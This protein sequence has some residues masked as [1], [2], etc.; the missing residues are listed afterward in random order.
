M[1]RTIESLQGIVSGLL[2][3]TIGNDFD[4]GHTYHPSML[5]RNGVTENLLPNT[6]GCARLRLLDKEF[7]AAAAALHNPKLAQ[8]DDAI[9]PHTDG[10][11]P[12]VDG[13]PRLNGILDT[14]RASKAHNIPIPS[15]FENANVIN[16]VE[17]AVC[18]EWFGAYHAQ[19]KAVRQQF[20][21]LAMG[22]FFFE[23][24]ERLNAKA[25]R[26]SSTPLALALYSTHDTSLAGILNTLDVFDNKWPAFTASLG[27]E[28]FKKDDDLLTK[29]RLKRPQHCES[30]E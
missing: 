27:I 13:H 17:R 21:R 28:L 19:D 25:F 9:K 18:D 3:Q 7:A 12:R 22:R 2:P 16:V 14:V 15:I 10:K 20:R 6:F 24:S 8:F 29:L 11:P 23:L 1:S 26:P 5:V 30:G 4:A